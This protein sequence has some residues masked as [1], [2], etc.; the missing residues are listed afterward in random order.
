MTNLVKYFSLLILQPEA[1]YY[2]YLY[3]VLAFSLCVEP[4]GYIPAG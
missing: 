1:K 3:S 2:D 4:V